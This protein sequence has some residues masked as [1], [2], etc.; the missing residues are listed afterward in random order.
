INYGMRYEYHPPFLDAL[1]NIAVF[2]PDY[3]AL[4]VRGAVAVPDPGMRLTNSIFAASIAPTPI[5]TASQ[6]GLNNTLHRSQKSSF[7][8]RIGF[9]WRPFANGKTVIRGGYGRFI[10]AML[11][12]L[13]SAGWAVSASSVGSYTNSLVNGKPVL[14][15]ASPFPA[16]LAQPGI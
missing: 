9:A 3:Y 10:E 1:D 16:N 7:A 12:T 14:T 2:L 13:T 15:M 5:L 11:G 6:V 4:G 8:P